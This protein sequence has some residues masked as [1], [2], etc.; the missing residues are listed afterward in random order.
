MDSSSQAKTILVQRYI[1]ADNS[2]G[3]S[4]PFS[5]RI[6]DYLDELWVYALQREGQTLGQFEEFFTKTPLGRYIA[7]ADRQ[8]QQEFFQRYLQDYISMTMKVTSEEQLQLFCGALTCCV[9]ELRA[10]LE[11]DG[12]EVPTLPWVHAA[13]EEF[14]NRL[15]NFSRMLIIE[16]KIAQVLLRNQYSIVGAELCRYLCPSISVP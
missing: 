4:M 16:P 8:M 13:Y 5:W 10:R 15:Q 3:C 11:A 7:D 9:N 6:K 2:M 12:D 14:K 1:T